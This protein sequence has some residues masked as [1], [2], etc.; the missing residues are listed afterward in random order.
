MYMRVS[1]LVGALVPTPM[2]IHCI[3]HIPAW[4]R[5]H[6]YI[7]AISFLVDKSVRRTGAAATN[8]QVSWGG[9]AKVSSVPMYMLACTYT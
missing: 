7:P 9:R 8:F 2:Y 6:R 3:R 5:A 1:N 4:P